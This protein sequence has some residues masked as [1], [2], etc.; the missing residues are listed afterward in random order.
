MTFIAL[1]LFVVSA[2]CNIDPR[3]SGVPSGVQEAVDRI[4]EDIA[5][6]R[7]QKIYDEAAEEWRQT[8]TPEETRA[9]LEQLRTRLGRV[10]SRNFHTGRDSQ[11]ASG[12]DLSGHVLII[13]YETD[14]ERGN[15]MESFTFVERDGRWL[16]AKYFVSSDALKQ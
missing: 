1:L 15:G 12:G 6:G 14:F 8:T 16:L 9:T 10:E 7:F 5:G 13:T 3:Q 2:A 11:N 4:T